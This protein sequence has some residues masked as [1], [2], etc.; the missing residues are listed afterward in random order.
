MRV[1]RRLQSWHLGMYM[2][3]NM[4][5]PQVKQVLQGCVT[6][7]YSNRTP[8]DV[9]RVI[10]SETAGP[11]QASHLL[12][13]SLAAEAGIIAVAL[14]A[15]PPIPDKE[16]QQGES[17]EDELAFMI[18]GLANVPVVADLRVE[19]AAGD[20]QGAL[21]SMLQLA[22]Q[23]E[24]MQRQRDEQRGRGGR[25]GGRGRGGS[26][27]GGRDQGSATQAGA[28]QADEATPR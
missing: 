1:E 15:P 13:Q 21:T 20:S 19:Q 11:A 6:A 27:G 7:L 22:D 10:S 5:Q 4:S 18:S 17:L 8:S 3:R 9:F 12:L 23:R 26:R 28:H 24:D 25:G 2:Q 16:E 14:R